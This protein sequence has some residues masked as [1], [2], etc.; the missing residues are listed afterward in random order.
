MV[1]L[2][3]KNVAYCRS[4][5]VVFKEKL[6]NLN[7]IPNVYHFLVSQIK[8][9]SALSTEIYFIKPFER[10]SLTQALIPFL[11]KKF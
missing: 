11:L 8:N 1:L 10:A 5:E 4:F 3:Q 7:K 9:S 6:S 2:L